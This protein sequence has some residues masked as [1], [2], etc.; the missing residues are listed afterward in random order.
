MTFASRDYSISRQ[1]A[2][3]DNTHTTPS[4]K[5]TSAR[6]KT[7]I[8]A[9]IFISRSFCSQKRLRRNSIW[10]GKPGNN[11]L[12]N[13]TN[14]RANTPT[15]KSS[16]PFQVRKVYWTITMTGVC[17]TT[18]RGFAMGNGKSSRRPSPRLALPPPPTTHQKKK[19]FR[20]IFFSPDI[21]KRKSRR[22]S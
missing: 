12:F 6:N 20:E 13:R 21:G 3:R 16:R 2:A 8:A 7:R 10:N 1:R 5:K 4:P 19:R 18:S 14:S 15:G 22:C 9:R 11:S 17:R